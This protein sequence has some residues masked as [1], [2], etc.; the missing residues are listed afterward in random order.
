MK[1]CLIIKVLKNALSLFI[2]LAGKL[3][4]NYI[5]SF[6]KYFMENNLTKTTCFHKKG[7]LKEKKKKNMCL[8][9]KSNIL[10]FKSRFE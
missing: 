5:K 10:H 9:P 1:V 3:C 6:S 7:I 8:F 2:N 4:I